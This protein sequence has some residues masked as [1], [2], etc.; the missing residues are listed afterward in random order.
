MD[1]TIGEVT[2]TE[3]QAAQRCYSTYN[4]GGT[5]EFDPLKDLNLPASYQEVLD[6]FRRLQGERAVEVL[7]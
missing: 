4:S 3:E 6:R 5:L 2:E 1:L 7:N